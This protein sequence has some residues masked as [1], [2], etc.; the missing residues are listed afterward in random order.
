MTPPRLADFFL[1]KVDG[2]ILLACFSALYIFLA[3]A[4][5]GGETWWILDIINGTNV[6]YG[7]DAYRFFLAKSSWLEASS[8]TY[9]FVLPAALALDGAV[10]TVAGGDLFWSRSIHGV[11][12][13]FGIFLLWDSGRALGLNRVAM[14][15]ACIIMGLLPRFAFT[16]LSF[17]GEFWLGFFICLALWLLVHRHYFLLAIASGVL[18]L[19]RPEGIYLFS[20]LFL[21][22]ALGKQWRNAA[23]SVVPGFIY[24][25]FLIIA[26]DNPQDYMHW[27]EELKNILVKIPFNHG[28]WEILNTYTA[29]L[30]IPGIMGLFCKEARR[31][32][33]L[34]LGAIVSILILQIFVLLGLA[35][36]EERYTYS[37]VPVLILLWAFFASWAWSLLGNVFNAKII[38]NGAV[39]LLAIVAVLH[40]LGQLTLI[41]LKIQKHSLTWVIDRALKGEW[42]RLF[43]HHDYT[44][45]SSRNAM[46]ERIQYALSADKGIDRLIIQDPFLYYKLDP[47]AIPNHVVVGYPATT[48]MIFHLLMNGQVFIQHSEG[49]HYDYIQFGEPDFRAG[50]SRALYVDLVPMT[51]YPHSWKYDGLFY[52]LYLFSYLATSSPS[53]D[54]SS[55]PALE[56]EDIDRAWNEWRSVSGAPREGQ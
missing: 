43:I 15:G 26:C 39:V 12:G 30:V 23:T 33:P 6:F 3:W 24:F 21:F 17:Y 7:D 56:R 29:F 8:Y 25:V 9:N 14:I 16:T 27:R 46:A 49:K 34:I 37:A 20:C 51:G 55:V 40:G 45:M 1:E 35:K 44:A 28:R 5:S 48:Y 13:A 53:V 38:K 36:F 50:E 32:W 22:F 47:A 18:P 19:L 31:I 52:Q 10:T 42:G 54:I 4:V 41:D 2:I 11:L